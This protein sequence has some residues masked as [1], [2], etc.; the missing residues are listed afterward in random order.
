MTSDFESLDDF[1]SS[2]VNHFTSSERNSVEYPPVP[3]AFAPNPDACNDA[4][5]FYRNRV[6]R[7]SINTADHGIGCLGGRS[8]SGF[9]ESEMNKKSSRPRQTRMG[10]RKPAANLA[11]LVKRLAEVKA[12]REMVQVAEAATPRRN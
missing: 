1:F 2:A 7:R 4:L 6:V 9:E 10:T 11:S 5:W 8:G 12:L 3:G